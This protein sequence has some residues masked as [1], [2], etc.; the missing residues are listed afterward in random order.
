MQ[1]QQR[2]HVIAV[3]ELV[4]NEE[5]VS[6][7]VSLFVKP[8]HFV[9]SSPELN[10]SVMEEEDRYILKVKSSAFAHYVE[11]SFYEADG[12]FSDNYFDLVS[13]KEKEVTVLKSEFN[14][15]GWKADQVLSDL[16]IKSVADSY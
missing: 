15:I 10:V 1:G 9:F 5:V 16:R 14:R 11:L 7:G 13:S 4:E 2:K 12:V 3:Y 6:G 8:K